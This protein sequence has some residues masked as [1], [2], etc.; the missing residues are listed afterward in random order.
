MST[1]EM[2]EELNFDLILSW[3]NKFSIPYILKV[4]LS[5][6]FVINIITIF[7]SQT[8]LRMSV[9]NTTPKRKE[10]YKYE[11]PWPVYSMNWS[12]RP[13]KRFR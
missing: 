10:I 3:I 2:S 1:N 12:V 9:H 8:K 4:L 7:S 6:T 13:D 11:A 5:I